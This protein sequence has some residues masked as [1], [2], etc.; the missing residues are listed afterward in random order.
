MIDLTTSHREFTFVKIQRDST[1]Q[2]FLQCLKTNEV[3][4][5]ELPSENNNT[6]CFFR[7][8]CFLNMPSVVILCGRPRNSIIWNTLTMKTNFR[9]YAT[10]FPTIPGTHPPVLMEPRPSL[11][12]VLISSLEW[13]LSSTWSQLS[14]SL[15]SRW[16]NHNRTHLSGGREENCRGREY[17]SQNCKW[18]ILFNTWDAF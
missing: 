1:I 2:A 4:K 9:E 15:A 18:D 13:R 17:E 14:L 5:I 6:C 3:D 10:H 16:W 11:P 8:P 7:L 12:W